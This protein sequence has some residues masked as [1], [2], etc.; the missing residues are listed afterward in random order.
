MMMFSTCFV[1][2]FSIYP[3]TDPWDDCIFYLHEELIFMVNVGK[4]ASPTDPT[5]IYSKSRDIENMRQRSTV[6]MDACSKINTFMEIELKK[7]NLSYQMKD[8]GHLIL[9]KASRL[10]TVPAQIF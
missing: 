10:M 5:D 1:V 7:G 2:M 8:P 3:M 6:R 9:K 4:Y